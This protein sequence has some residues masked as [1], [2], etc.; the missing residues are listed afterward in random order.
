MGSTGSSF[1]WIDFNCVW[2]KTYLH[3]SDSLIWQP[4]LF[5]GLLKDSENVIKQIAFMFWLCFAAHAKPQ[6]DH[7]P[8]H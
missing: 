6:E 1:F 4:S 2:D 7:L 8:N 3:F 5:I